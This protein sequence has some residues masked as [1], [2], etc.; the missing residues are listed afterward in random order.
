M[1]RAHLL[2]LSVTAA[3]GFAACREDAPLASTQASSSS[4]V[5]A[6]AAGG[7]GGAAT[8]TASAAGGQGGAGG[9]EHTRSSAHASSSSTSGAGGGCQ[10]A[11]PTIVDPPMLLSQTGLYDDPATLKLSPLAR[12]YEPQFMLWSDGEAKHR[13]IYLPECGTID[14]TDMD[15]W[16]LPVG[17]RAWKEFSFAGKRLETRLMVKT[18]PDPKDLLYATYRWDEGQTDGT[19]V[20]GGEKNVLGTDHDIPD[21]LT[22]KRCHGP[23][24]AKGGLPSRYLGF[25]AIQLSHD[26][27]GVTLTTLINEQR[28]SS[29]PAGNFTVPGD[30]IERAALGYL[31]VNCGMCHNDTPDGFLFPYFNAR[32]KTTDADLASTGVYKTMVNKKTDNF[33]G[34]GCDYRIAGGSVADSCAYY[35]MTERGTAMSPNLKQMPPVGTEVIDATGL[36]TL[37]AW[38]ETLPPPVP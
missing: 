23:Y 36:A 24:P 5:G 6:G 7:Q 27:P 29:P 10:N 20:L 13:Y 14:T 4:A 2:A 11:L 16:Q 3:A 30:A 33:L 17:T 9:E 1:N 37:G 22:C 34:Y 12:E 38:I 19:L 32:V 31:H 18:G 15:V 28:L 35:R 25:G 26:G 8:A 21:I